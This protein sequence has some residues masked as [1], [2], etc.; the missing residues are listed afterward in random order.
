MAE[1]HVDGTPHVWRALDETFIYYCTYC[2][3][4]K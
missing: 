3:V 4:E 2:G 1:R